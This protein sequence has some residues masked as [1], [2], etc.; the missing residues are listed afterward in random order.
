MSML[1]YLA[2]IQTCWRSRRC[3]QSMS[4]GSSNL[5]EIE[6]IKQRGTQ[7][8]W[9]GLEGSSRRTKERA[10][11]TDATC[12]VC[13]KLQFILYMPVPFILIKNFCLHAVRLASAR[14][15]ALSYLAHF[16]YKAKMRIGP[17]RKSE[18]THYLRV[19]SYHR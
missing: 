9:L 6:D 2:Q 8:A 19:D 5:L 11:W 14:Q 17:L 4:I 18:I 3:R 15:A 1:I 13:L 16:F 12:F 10:R 7:G